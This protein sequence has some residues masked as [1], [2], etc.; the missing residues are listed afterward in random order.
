MMVVIYRLFSCFQKVIV[1]SFGENI[2]KSM[3]LFRRNHCTSHSRFVSGLWILRGELSLHRLCEE[4]NF[5]IYA[6]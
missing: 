3:F 2:L 5:R 6:E 1:W 4:Q